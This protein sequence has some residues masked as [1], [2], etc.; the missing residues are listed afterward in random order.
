MT[1]FPE[2][3]R[4]V[5]YRLEGKHARPLCKSKL[6]SGIRPRLLPHSIGTVLPPP[7][8]PENRTGR[9]TTTCARCYEIAQ[10]ILGTHSPLR[11]A[12]KPAHHVRQ[13]S[14]DGKDQGV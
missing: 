3:L 10:G 8:V 7:T 14:P 6:P 1:R 12:E 9:W 13:P 2:E 5:H 4:V 11:I